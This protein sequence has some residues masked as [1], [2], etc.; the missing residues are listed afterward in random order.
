MGASEQNSSSRIC[1]VS[2][3]LA[4]EADLTEQ[5]KVYTSPSGFQHLFISAKSTMC[6]QALYIGR[7]VDRLLHRYHLT[8]QQLGTSQP[9]ELW[10]HGIGPRAIERTI[11][12]ALHLQNR[13]YPGHLAT[14]VCTSTCSA[15]RQIIA[16]IAPGSN[17]ITEKERL[18]SAIHIC[19][20]LLP[21]RG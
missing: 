1:E 17:S 14:S 15:I 5:I 19:L 11:E 6:S 20:R 9:G 13:M 2:E 21:T 18:K 4:D 7:L 3:L 16:A 8:S 12:L 10:L